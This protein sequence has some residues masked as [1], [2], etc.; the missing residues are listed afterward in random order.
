MTLALPLRIVSDAISRDCKAVALWKISYQLE[1]S[2][3]A[4]APSP[5]GNLDGSTRR[6][7]QEVD[8]PSRCVD[9]AINLLEFRWQDKTVGM[10]TFP[11]ECRSE[12][13]SRRGDP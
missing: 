2:T 12:P 9:E 6:Q 1:L 7:E 4:D 11:G 8:P 5:N 3:Q 10:L 13:P